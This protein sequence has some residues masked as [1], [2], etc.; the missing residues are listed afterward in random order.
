MA[1]AAAGVPSSPQRC[2]A[3]PAAGRREV[4]PTFR[5]SLP[6]GPGEST[7]GSYTPGVAP[8]A[9]PRE[10][11][12]SPR[13]FCGK[14][15]SPRQRIAATGIVPEGG[16]KGIEATCHRRQFHQ[17]PAVDSDTRHQAKAVPC[18]KRATSPW[19]QAAP[20]SPSPR[21][22]ED[23]PDLFAA[24]GA[25]SPRAEGLF[26]PCLARAS[27]WVPPKPAASGG[28]ASPRQEVPHR[29]S[30]GWLGSTCCI[31]DPVD[32]QQRAASP[33]HLDSEGVGRV[34]RGRPESPQK[35]RP[36]R[37]SSPEG[38]DG[39]PHAH[40]IVH[41]S[42]P[43][44]KGCEIGA[45]STTQKKGSSPAARFVL[46]GTVPYDTDASTV[47]ATTTCV[48][49]SPR[50]VS[51]Y[52]L[53]DVTNGAETLGLRI[54]SPTPTARRSRGKLICEENMRIRACIADGTLAPPDPVPTPRLAN[55]RPVLEER[56]RLQS[57][58]EKGT[59]PPR[60]LPPPRAADREGERGPGA[61]EQAASVP[62]PPP[63]SNG[64]A[65]TPCTAQA[66]LTARAHLADSPAAARRQTSPPTPRAHV[67]DSPATVLRDAP[68]VAQQDAAAAN[69]R[70]Q[71]PWQRPVYDGTN[72]VASTSASSGSSHSWVP[73]K[74]HAP[75]PHV[76]R[77]HFGGA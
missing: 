3:S 59:Y 72:S 61:G 11:P 38:R 47:G 58:P 14:A 56:N 5:S 51:L 77:R 10:A 65:R 76:A 49:T 31:A 54:G 74:T 45:A 25:T 75:R 15:M 34:L 60:V 28:R 42:S 63:P 22:A 24:A 36:C 57:L 4:S 73:L 71:R 29:R 33:R 66:P 40:R 6:F 53:S 64:R 17:I 52:R 2:P 30:E 19:A 62:Q 69:P 46:S 9:T 48:P 35:A 21:S 1:P 23:A 67:Q 37:K 41:A 26:S 8:R 18:R 32:A 55:L 44:L 39:L 7:Y 50:N 12:H 70:Q 20:R 68:A 13:P 43:L 27:S 16:L